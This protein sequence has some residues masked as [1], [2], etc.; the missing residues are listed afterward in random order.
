MRETKTFLS[1]A[2]FEFANITYAFT[3]KKRYGK[4]KEA[5]MSF[6]AN[7]DT[8]DGDFKEGDDSDYD[9]ID[10]ELDSINEKVICTDKFLECKIDNDECKD[11]IVLTETESL[12]SK[13]SNQ[14]NVDIEN[15][16]NLKIG[17]EN[18]TNCRNSNDIITESQ[19]N[20]IIN[21]VSL[22]EKSIDDMS[23]VDSTF[24]TLNIDTPTHQID[25]KEVDEFFNSNDKKIENDKEEIKNEEPDDLR[26]TLI[27]NVEV[28]DHY[29]SA[30]KND[31]NHITYF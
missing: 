21:L 29:N 28:I 20:K 1:R 25:V 11:L 18:Q 23:N 4:N 5:V 31:D 14:V 2:L 3:L 8:N 7:I 9:N 15:D 19:T 22:G 24:I 26:S 17:D 27:D 6:E 12:H 30:N 10:Q 13:T 16:E